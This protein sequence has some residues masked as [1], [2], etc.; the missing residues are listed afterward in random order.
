MLFGRCDSSLQNL[1]GAYALIS[2][3]RRVVVAGGD[4][5]RQQD[6]RAAAP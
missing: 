3:V 2:V 4:V 6:C 1:G 5:L